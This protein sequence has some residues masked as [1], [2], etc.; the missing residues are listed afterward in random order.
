MAWSAPQAVEREV[1]MGF[2]KKNDWLILTGTEREILRTPTSSVPIKFLPGPHGTFL[3][4][5]TVRWFIHWLRLPIPQTQFKS[6]FLIT[7]FYIHFSACPDPMEIVYALTS[8]LPA[9][10]MCSPPPQCILCCCALYLPWESIIYFLC[11]FHCSWPLL[12]A[13]SQH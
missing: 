11:M 13:H 12:S 1:G 10:G 2:S 8:L 4:S 6:Y 7:T 9:L 3:P 5:L